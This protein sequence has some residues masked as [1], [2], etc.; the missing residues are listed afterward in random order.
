MCLT[1]TSRFKI[2]ESKS[3]EMK[4][5]TRGSIITAN[6]QVRPAKRKLRFSSPFKKTNDLNTDQN[7]FENVK[8]YKL[9]WQTVGL[10]ELEG[11]MET[12]EVD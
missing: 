6:R 1:L 5:S 10:G 4:T 3:L 7:D 8:T 12:P 11:P 2:L 9:I